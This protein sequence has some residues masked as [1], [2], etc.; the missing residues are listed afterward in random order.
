[1]CFP[2]HEDPSGRIIAE[3]DFNM[4]SSSALGA[5]SSKGGDS[6]QHQFLSDLVRQIVAM[7]ADLIGNV[8]V[9]IHLRAVP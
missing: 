6:S 4:R 1:M 2:I 5:F 3:V 7:R 8:G 9:V